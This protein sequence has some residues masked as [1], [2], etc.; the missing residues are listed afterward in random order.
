MQGKERNLKMKYVHKQVLLM[1]VILLLFSMPE[2]GGITVLARAT[3]TGA[4]PESLETPLGGIHLWKTDA[5]DRPLAD[6]S[7]RIARLTTE[8]EYGDKDVI[9]EAL[10]V[11]GTEQIVVFVDFYPNASMTG[12]KIYEV[13]TDEH[14]KAA[15]YGLPYGTYFLLE[16][17]APAGYDLLNEPIIVAVNE[18]SHL[19]EADGV[20]DG[21]RHRIDNTIHIVNT[22]LVL[23]GTGGMGTKLFTTLGVVL[24]SSAGLLILSNYKKRV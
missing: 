13:T 24:L 17:K 23:P 6:V 12:E 22:K 19:T 20:E 1:L 16:T 8:E 9:K 15:L 5:M 4:A 14:G 10:R 18:S 7:F 3:D 21:Q 2:K 11:G